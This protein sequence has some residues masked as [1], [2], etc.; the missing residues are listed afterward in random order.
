MHPQLVKSALLHGARLMSLSVLALLQACHVGPNFL[1]P[2]PPK[3]ARYT[4]DSLPIEQS[5]AA[6]GTQHLALGK[7]IE[8]DWWSLFA[9]DAIDG[10]VKQALESGQPFGELAQTVTGLPGGLEFTGTPE[11]LADLV[12]EWV[13]RGGSDGFTLQPTTIPESLELFVDHVIPILQHRGLHR[14]Q[15][16]GTTLRDHLDLQRPPATTTERRSVDVRS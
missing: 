3:A 5:E 6:A 1:R 16:A 13:T 8:G 7:E 15:Y 11:Q 12:E 14:R 2:E 10:I 9:S 4:A